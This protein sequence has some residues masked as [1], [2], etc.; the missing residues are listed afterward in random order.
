MRRIVQSFACLSVLVLGLAPLEAQSYG[1]IS[2]FALP[3]AGQVMMDAVVRPASRVG[4]TQ[5]EE[6]QTDEQTDDRNP[7]YRGTRAD[8]AR[9]TYSGALSPQKN[10]RA[11]K[12]DDCRDEQE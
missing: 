3:H 4:V 8:R 1:I 5:I 9:C 2:A 6:R 11:R 10:G 7:A 12:A